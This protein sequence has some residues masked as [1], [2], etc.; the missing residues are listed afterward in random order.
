MKTG[1]NA[2]YQVMFLYGQEQKTYL[3][4]CRSEKTMSFSIAELVA[5][6]YQ[7]WRGGADRQTRARR[8]SG[9]R[10]T[11]MDTGPVHLHSCVKPVQAPM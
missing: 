8:I 11:D 4:L 2:D 7:G 6:H 9:V 3:P 1:S 10:E 5:K